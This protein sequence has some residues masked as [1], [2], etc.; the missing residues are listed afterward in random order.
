M[1]L[2]SLL[3]MALALLVAGLLSMPES[4][5]AK[6]FGGGG[7]IGKQS[8]SMPRQA[9]PPQQAQAPARGQPQTAAP[10][11][12]APQT[13]GASRWLGPLAGLAAGG[14]LASLFFGDAFQGFQIM[15]FLMIV[16]LVVGGIF[17][18]R[19]LRRGRAAPSAFGAPSPTPAPAGGAYARGSAAGGP[20]TGGLVPSGSL[21]ATPPRAAGSDQF[22]HWFDGPSF[23]AGAKGHFV[24]LQSAWDQGDLESIREYVTPELFGE[25]QQ[26]RARLGGPQQTEV[27]RLQAELLT[28]QREG[29]L[30]VASIRFSGLIREDAQGAAE[31]FNEVWHVQHLWAGAEGDWYIAGIQQV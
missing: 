7:S 13:G 2:K 22:P 3:T 29:D 10:G 4:A 14:L 15:D 9:Q 6:R 20:R 8:Q 23:I 17:L 24:Q 28:L 19:M 30:A 11:Q 12:R 25:L 27:V 5:E 26:E 1:K 31:P 21:G 16:L 18:F